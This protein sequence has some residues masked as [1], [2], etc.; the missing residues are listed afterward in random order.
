MGKQSTMFITVDADI[1]RAIA[2]LGKVKAAAREAAIA[3]DRLSKSGG[4]GGGG[5]STI[6]A[7]YSQTA[8]AATKAKEAVTRYAESHNLAITAEQKA[9]SSASRH[10][11][12]LYRELQAIRAAGGALTANQ[13]KFMADYRAKMRASAA[14][15]KA[16]ASNERLKRSMRSAGTSGGLV[17]AM[18]RFSQ[19]FINLRYQNP[20]G[21]IAGLVQGFK[22][23][24]SG[25]KFAAQPIGI[26]AIAIG[27][28]AAA[29][30]GAAAAIGA[31]GIAFA[32]MGISAAST[33]ERT[34]ISYEALLGS[35]ERAT[36]EVREL[37][38]LAKDSIVPTESLLE[39][40]RLLLAYGVTADGTRRQ[41]VRFFSDFAAA[42]G[43]PASRLN[44]LAYAL[45]QVESQGKANAI[46]MRQLANAGLNLAAVYEKIAEKQKIS[47]EEA[48]NLVTQGK[49]TSAVLYPAILE[50]GD[51]YKEAGDKARQSFSGIASN[52]GDIMQVQAGLAFEDT[53]AKLVPIMQAI[54]DFIGRLEPMWRNVGEAVSNA[55]GYISEA[56]T[57]MLGGVGEEGNDLAYFFNYTLP[58]AINEVAYQVAILI[59]AFKIMWLTVEL[60]LN[61]MNVG[62]QTMKMVLMGLIAAVMQGL[63]NILGPLGGWAQEVAN[64]AGAA[65]SDAASE[66]EGAV[67]NATTIV[68]RFEQE[69]TTPITKRATIVVDVQSA[70]AYAPNGGVGAG[71]GGGQIPAQATDPQPDWYLDMINGI[72]NAAVSSSGGSSGGGGGGGGGSKTD[73]RIAV[74]QKWAQDLKNIFAE[75]MRGLETMR[76]S[77]RKAFGE[78][79]QIEKAFRSGNIDSVIST[80]DSLTAA[81]KQFFGP[82]TMKSLVGEKAAKAARKEMNQILDGLEADAKRV[83]KLIREN[84]KL[85]KRREKR[86]EKEKKAIEERY[87]ALISAE[88]AKLEAL[89]DEYDAATAILEDLISKRDEFIQGLKDSSRQ[90]V[91]A[92]KLDQ[93]T[94]EEYYR[95]A[96]DGSFV[97][98]QKQQTKSF[99]DS[100]RERLDTLKDWWN[101]IRALK[102]RGLD[103]NLLQDLIAAGPESSAAAVNDLAQ[104]GQDVID[105]V[106][107]IQGELAGVSE[108][109]GDYVNNAWHQSGIDA[110]QGVV[111]NLQGMIDESKRL[112]DEL[113]A[114]RDQALVD[115]QTS[116]EN[117]TDELGQ[118]IKAN[119][120]TA[121]QISRQVQ[122]QFKEMS[123]S[124]Y[125]AGVETAYNLIEGMN[126]DSDK[127]VAAATA[128]ADKIAT[129]LKKALRN[130]VSGAVGASVRSGLEDVAFSNTP[131]VTSRMATVDPMT[132]TPAGIGDVHVYIGDRE[133]TD[134]VDVQIRTNDEASLNRVLAGRRL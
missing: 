11:A 94:T 52:L 96:G 90:F 41:L 123:K 47:V 15:D 19:S 114:E 69:F 99:R 84:E 79:S 134:L 62:F 97:I 38:S 117:Y 121:A 44:D 64:W 91:N 58:T 24:G 32:K 7:T 59:K 57:G 83:I 28:V 130:G 111:D 70:G 72:Q 68:K 124:A 30:I 29:S 86:Y 33:L 61:N 48:Q 56:V 98:K 129:A 17:T 113:E 131:K 45:G 109:M 8:V 127:I 81:T 82:A 105:E 110:A 34:R 14:A 78:L 31:V 42:T 120:K 95:L 49:L 39:A 21:V 40:N 71:R 76:T 115:L 118:Q 112:L 92:L 101:K 116:Y 4:V 25:A 73:P 85:E 26:A 55:I 65:A 2:K 53:L 74:W 103:E 54:E 6:T 80:F 107:A 119:E 108:G 88:A 100:M 106:N 37:Q 1:T 63:A 12:A 132:V 9:A 75:A 18:H 43:L 46:D 102:E 50:V 67:R 122:K 125:A 66:V 89:N 20:L 126:T 22:A 13:S 36:V 128:L 77:T 27:A 23:L 3:M 60:V 16:A 93:E 87:D 10:Q 51:A 35:A 5:S 104:A 133:L